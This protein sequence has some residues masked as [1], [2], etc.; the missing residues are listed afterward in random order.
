MAREV[1]LLVN[2]PKAAR[3]LSKRAN[4]KTDVDRT[5]ARKFDKEF[6]DGDRRHGY[7]GF[8]YSPR[9]WQPVVPTI[10]QHWDLKAGD[11]VLD[12]GCAKGFMLHD[13]QAEI[14]GLKI[15]GVDVSGYAIANSLES[16]KPFL[17]VANAR[18]LPFADSSFDYVI[19]I[20]TVH[21][22]A[23]DDCTRALSEIERVS[24]RGSFI[25]VDAYRDEAERKRME[26]WNLTALTIL[27]VN[28]WIDVFKE[29]G[30]SGDYFWFI[31]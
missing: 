4:D 31:P 28:E 11:S 30:Y 7:G 9:F 14:P 1:D 17:Q 21:N 26:D 13:F 16:V 12:I 8:A 22:L 15:E 24:R 18:E 27:S 19:S 20:N 29:A 25:T 10:Q 3:D 2:Y 6:F 23:I 5:I